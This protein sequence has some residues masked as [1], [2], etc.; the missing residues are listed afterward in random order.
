[1]TL[2][3]SQIKYKVCD[4]ITTSEYTGSTDELLMITKMKIFRKANKS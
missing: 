1:M 4:G 2:R 3:G